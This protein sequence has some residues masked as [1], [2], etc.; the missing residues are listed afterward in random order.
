M[1]ELED[2]TLGVYAQ[3]LLRPL[4]AVAQTA[5][6]DAGDRPDATMTAPGALSE[7]RLDLRPVP[8]ARAAG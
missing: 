7:L 5:Q 6:A 2:L 1:L 3:Q 4:A 8:H